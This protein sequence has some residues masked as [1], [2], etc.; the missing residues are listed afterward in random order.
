VSLY[1]IEAIDGDEF[2]VRRIPL[3]RTGARRL[4]GWGDPRSSP[5]QRWATL[6]SSGTY[7][8]QRG[9]LDHLYRLRL[10]DARTVYRAEPYDLDGDD[11]DDLALLRADGW[12]V[13]IGGSPCHHPT[14][15]VVSL[16]RLTKGSPAA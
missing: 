2:V 3:A 14:T 11:L 16:E 8:E 15:V 5:A 13:S 9:W 12:H 7:V 4:H 1:E 10:S 6:D